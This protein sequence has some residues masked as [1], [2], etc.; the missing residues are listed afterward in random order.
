MHMRFDS[1]ASTGW[2]RPQGALLAWRT[3]FFDSLLYWRFSA[4]EKEQCRANLGQMM[5]SMGQ[6]PSAQPCSTFCLLPETAAVVAELNARAR[7]L[8]LAEV[9]C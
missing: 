8:A 3:T 7:T 9:S 2:S 4:A 6:A 5:M 1:R